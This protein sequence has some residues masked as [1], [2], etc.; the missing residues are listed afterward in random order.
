MTAVGFLLFFPG[1]GNHDLWAPN[2]PVF[3][4]GAREMWER[5]NWLLPY[6]N[7]QV[8]LDKPILY[9]WAIL[10]SSLPA[11]EVTAWAARF[12]SALASLGMLWAVF[13]LGARTVSQRAGL[14]AALI[15]AVTP[16]FI[17]EARF[18]QMDPMLALFMF[19]CLVCFQRARETNAAWWL[20]ASGAWAGLAVLTKGPVGLVLPG[21]TAL[22]LLAWERD[23]RFL[24]RPAWLAGGAAFLLVGAPW[25]LAVGAAGHPEWLQ[26]F[27]LRQNVTRF[28]DPFDHARPWYYYGR[29]FLSDLF[30]WSLLLPLIA[31]DRPGEETSLP[32]RTTWRLCTLYVMVVLLF[33]SASGAKRGV[34]ILP[35][36]PAYALLVGR[37]WERAM[38]GKLAPG[39]RRSLGWL[40]LA[41]GTVLAI[42]GIALMPALRS[43]YPAFLGSAALVGGLMLVAGVLTAWFAA[44]RRLRASFTALTGGLAALYLAAFLVVIP[45]VDPLKS[46]RG[47]SERVLAHAGQELPLRSFR[48]W[49]WRSSY[50]FYTRRLMPVLRTYEEV[51]AYISQPGPAF[52][53]VE[54]EDREELESTLQGT[55]VLLETDSV[56]RRTIHLFGK[57]P[58]DDELRSGPRPS[59]QTTG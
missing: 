45:R 3:A 37:L 28:L 47:F 48:F 9:F 18:A 34:Y 59:G 50:I 38:S 6:V 13:L 55:V 42:G 2:E 40:T 4:E 11:G 23:L 53:L 49:K 15:L 21:A 17:W 43:R 46:A 24:R 33:F 41:G 19:L 29:R 54:D 22:L 16:I 51:A 12:P 52:L 26:E 25:F 7:G 36:Y 20:A 57:P 14:L 5:G 10:I 58:D 8:Y 32:E 27:F 44:R 56:G 30:P 31:L 39:R 35:M 1:L